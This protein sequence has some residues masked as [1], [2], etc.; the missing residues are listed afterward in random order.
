M[1]KRI[2]STYTSLSSPMKTSAPSG[3]DNALN[4]DVMVLCRSDLQCVI[5]GI[6]M[7]HDDSCQVPCPRSGARKG[8]GHPWL[9]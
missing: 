4:V 5:L 6:G 8:A 3:T 9:N 2:A 7:T 1:I